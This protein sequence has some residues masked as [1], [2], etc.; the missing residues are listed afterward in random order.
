LTSDIVLLTAGAPD[1][2]VGEIPSETSMT[3]ARPSH[4]ISV[5]AI[6]AVLLLSTSLLVAQQRPRVSPHSA[7]SAVVEGNRVSIF[8]GR[9]YIKDPRTSEPRKIWGGLVPFDRVWRTGAN[10]ATLLT[11]QEPIQ[12]GET[13]IPAGAY[14]LFTLPAEDGTA[15]LIINSQIG[16]WGNQYDESQ[17][18]ARLPLTRTD[19]AE[20]VDQFTI[21]VERG[22]EENTGIIKMSWENAEYSVGFKKEAKDTETVPS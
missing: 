15:T 11:T 14:S 13:V 7:T 4:F 20:P 5:L 3:N 18:V 2:A 16:Q 21:S 9:P 19:L 10:E 6:F 17:D 12:I 1:D 8:Y 22:T